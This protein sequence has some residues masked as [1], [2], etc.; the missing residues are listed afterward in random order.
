MTPPSSSCRVTRGVSTLSLY[1]ASKRAHRVVPIQKRLLL[2]VRLRHPGTKPA[3]AAPIPSCFAGEEEK[4]ARSG[5][6]GRGAHEGSSPSH[7][8][9]S[10]SSASTGIS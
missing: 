2:S 5:A 9:H 10:S 3:S 7:R 4:T 1:A 6:L 8:N